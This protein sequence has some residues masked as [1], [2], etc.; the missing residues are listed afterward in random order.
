MNSYEGRKFDS[1]LAEVPWPNGLGVRMLLGSNY[2]VEQPYAPTPPPS[3]PLPRGIAEAIPL[4]APYDTGY[5]TRTLADVIVNRRSGNISGDSLSQAAFAT[6]LKATAEGMPKA[7]LPAPEMEPILFPLVFSVEGLSPGVY[8]YLPCK[9]ALVAVR[10]VQPDVVSEDVLLQREHGNGAALLFLVVPMARWLHIF[11]DRGYRGAAFQA[12]W[13]S[14]RLYLVAE[15]L[16]L[17]YAASGG[18]AAA[19]ADALLKL[20][21]YHYTPLL[22]F[23]VGGPRVES[24]DSAP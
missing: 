23:V 8:R 16:G 15:N 19:A 14:D 1:V 6:L 4:A 7:F 12:G 22:L 11:G 24:S 3:L 5:S 18:F 2:P 17:T 10:P 13:L 21:G 9:H 20:D